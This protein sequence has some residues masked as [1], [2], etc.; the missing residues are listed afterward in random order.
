[1]RLVL[2]GQDGTCLC[3]VGYQVY[4]AGTEDGNSSNSTH[5]AYQKRSIAWWPHAGRGDTP[6][7]PEHAAAERQGPKEQGDGKDSETER[8][9][10]DELFE[11]V[12]GLPGGLGMRR[13]LSRHY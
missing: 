9:P 11:R 12:T 5:A 4:T 6:Q 13:Y 2:G 8:D 7:E 1:M 10:E 3:E